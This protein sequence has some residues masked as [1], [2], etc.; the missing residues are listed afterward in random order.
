MNTQTT[1]I[2]LCAG[3][4]TR[5][6]DSSTNKVCFEV[7]G[8]PVVKRII[9]S[10]RS[11]GITS[12]IV[13]VGYRAEK[14]MQ[15]LADE[16]GVLYAFQGEQNGT[17]SAAL[18][19]IEA[20]LKFGYTGDVIV[21]A[22]D[23][24][25]DANLIKQLLAKKAENGLSMVFGAQTREFNRNGG[26]VVIENGRVYGIVESTDSAL[27]ALKGST[28]D[29]YMKIL[30][31][32]NLGER[33]NT[34]ILQSVTEM[35]TLSP[36]MNLCGEEF[37]SD[38]IEKTNYI[39]GS[40]YCFNIVEAEEA[41][42]SLN[43][44][45]AQG[46]FYLTDMVNYFVRNHKVDILP[47][48]EYG[49]MMTYSTKEELQQ[50]NCYF[51]SRD[52]TPVSGWIS[53]IDAL[54]AKLQA[55]YGDS[56]K[57]KKEQIL[58]TLRLFR[59]RFGDSGVIIA[60]APGR[61]NL[62]G[63][64]VD[65]RGGCTNMMCTPNET[66]FVVS[67]RNDGVV[68]ISNVD[69]AF[70]DYSFS[71]SGCM[72]LSDRKTS[73]L[74]F[75]ESKAVTKDVEKN[76]G[77]WVNYVKSAVL[78]FQYEY[79]DI[80]LSGMN[81]LMTGNVPIAAGLSSSSSIVVAAAEAVVALNH[82]DVAD[83]D[84]VTMCGEGEWLVGTRGG[85]GDHAAI[86]CSSKDRIT[87]MFFKPFA[88][89]NTVEFSSDYK[90]VV[91][92][93]RISAKKS[94]GTRDRFNQ[95]V[96]CYEFGMM[97]INKFYPQYDGRLVYLRDFN[98]IGLSDMDIY[99]MLM[100]LP[101]RATSDDLYDLLPERAED[102]RRIQKSHAIPPFYEIRSVMLFGISEC[103]RSEKACDVIAAGDYRKLGEMMN[104]SH[105]GDRVYDGSATHDYF[106]SD[107]ML[108]RLIHNLSNGVDIEASRIINQSGGYACSTKEID[109][110]VDLA[111]AQPGVLGAQIAGAGLGGSVIILVRSGYEDALISSL[112][113]GYYKP[114]HL[115][116]AINVFSPACG[117]SV[118]DFK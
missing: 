9:S 114:A 69:P 59:E 74:D 87:H 70:G 31:R 5:M 75:I 64:H 35:G 18:C 40:L 89:G 110:L 38:R 68:S 105:N 92:D 37:D 54:D 13:V 44:D 111:C 67:P 4:G 23:K 33:K 82:L 8:V 48:T 97:L 84:F 112:E 36:T 58:D 42:H 39:N 16:K 46:E 12:F 103:L 30:S 117:A 104:I 2:I 63:R 80:P 43:A 85:S 101:Q 81:I 41:I 116:M 45:N 28:S 77:A 26:R 47:I 90:I 62:M 3:K 51:L 99:R 11:A 71:I 88:V 22:G 100:T 115:E 21:S 17:G 25:L 78:R 27:M 15:C 98:R 49:Q 24:I 66:L 79:Q 72:A 10:F 95:Q 102:I 76:K 94:E 7:G 52:L 73:W 109:G 61:L 57:A 113:D 65:H 91:A 93:S 20:A 106:V 60:R 50:L 86:K 53:G 55:T 107:E 14:V 6:N 29:Q 96:A 83:S 56:A 34:K 1:A 118:I 19:G 108:E 32:F